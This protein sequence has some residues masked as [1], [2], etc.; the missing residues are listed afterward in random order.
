MQ[1]SP[2]GFEAS[3]LGAIVES[4]PIGPVSEVQAILLLK[5][6]HPYS[7]IHSFIHACMRSLVGPGRTSLSFQ[8]PERFGEASYQSIRT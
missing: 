1:A 8:A 3:S 5:W 4:L 6:E 7:H 2:Q